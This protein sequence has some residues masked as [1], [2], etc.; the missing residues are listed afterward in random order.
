MSIRILALVG[1]LALS[2]AGYES[3]A[4][5]E[6]NQARADLPQGQVELIVDAKEYMERI[7][8]TVTLATKG[9]YGPL[10]RGAGA[11]LRYSRDRIMELLEGHATTTE[12]DGKERV[13]LVNAEEAIKSV[14]RNDNRDRMVCVLAPGT[15]SRIATRECM[16][17]GQREDRAKAARRV[18]ADNQHSMN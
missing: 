15:G 11:R 10:R 12:L 4:A 2:S 7:N 17:V 8:N 14:I 3:A 9:E 6:R 16:T 18:T 1:V 5:S 13:A